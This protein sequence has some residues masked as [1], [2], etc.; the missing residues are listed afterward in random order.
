MHI[1]II[2]YTYT[3]TLH[4][5]VGMGGLAPAQLIIYMSIHCIMYIQS[6]VPLFL[7]ISVGVGGGGIY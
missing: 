6:A 3:Y 1:R 4:I 7:Y 2:N 5:L